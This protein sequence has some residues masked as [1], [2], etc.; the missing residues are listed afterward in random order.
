MRAGASR[1]VL[2]YDGSEGARRALERA[3]E[4][5]GY[6][7]HVTVVTVATSP[8][9]PPRRLLEEARTRL[10]GR[11]VAADLREETGEPAEQ[12]LAVARDV[13]AELVVV[14]GSATPRP[15]LGSVAGQVA[16]AA[17]CDVFVVN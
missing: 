12:L 8:G 14:G 6:G 9:D 15:V 4:L 13:G 3:A 10:A 2:G 16:A 11:L 17:T 1:I 5:A 7:S